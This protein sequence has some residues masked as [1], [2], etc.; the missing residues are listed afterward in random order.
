LVLRTGVDRV[1][2]WQEQQP[3]SPA[4]VDAGQIGV[5]GTMTGLVDADLDVDVLGDENRVQGGKLHQ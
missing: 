2:G 5:G 4:V 3:Q 1:L